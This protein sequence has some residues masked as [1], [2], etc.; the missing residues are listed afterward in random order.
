MPVFNAEAFLA[1]AVASV[2]AQTGCVAWEL[3]LID[4][5]STDGSRALAANLQRRRPQQIRLLRHWDGRNHGASAARNLGLREARARFV[6]F[7]DA[8]D[9][10]LPHMLETQ[11]AL[12]TRFPQA[13]MVYGHAERAWN[14]ALPYDPTRGCLGDNF[15]PTL[16]PDGQADGLLPP[17]QPLAWFLADETLTPC[18]CTVMVRTAVAQQ[19]GGFEDEFAG[20][21]DDQAFYAKI[22]LAHRVA[23]TTTCL[24]RYRVHATSCCGQGWHNQE[25]RQTARAHFDRWLAGYRHA[26]LPA[27][28][29]D[30]VA[31]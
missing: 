27:P 18:T 5:G 14:M 24:A 23:V 9:V 1:E 31:S 22:M 28:L 12:L 30:L 6:T 3:L 25:L 8:D 20:L 21:Y 10:W 29:A 19:V 15:L 2:L 7:L 16:L 4:D 13:A 26:N 17:G 11:L